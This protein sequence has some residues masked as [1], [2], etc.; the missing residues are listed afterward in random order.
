MKKLIL[1]F[2][3]LM[4]AV[5]GHTKTLRYA[6]PVAETGFD[7]AQIS[8]LYSHTITAN[9]FESLYRYD[10]A[11]RPAKIVP[12]IATAMPE[13]SDHFRTFTI[14]I[15]KG[16]YFADDPAFGGKKRELTAHDY[17]YSI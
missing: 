11:A 10:Y 14:R 1:I 15:Q 8:D 2:I 5:V 7:P 9:I 17:V 13:I 3:L 12:N 16:I 4:N 6:F